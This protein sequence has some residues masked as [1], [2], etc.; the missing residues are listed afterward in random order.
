MSKE[1]CMIDNCI[2]INSIEKI[3][4][5]LK[6]NNDDTLLALTTIN[7]MK[8]K[9]ENV[10]K[11][12]MRIEDKFESLFINMEKRFAWKWVENYLNWWVKLILWAVI[13]ALVWLVIVVR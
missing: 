1:N 2:Q 4:K 8:E 13:V 9:I 10:E 3:E 11:A 12:V 5:E 6:K 7:F